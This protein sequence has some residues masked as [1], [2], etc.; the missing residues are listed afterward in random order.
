VS[1]E[2]FDPSQYVVEPVTFQEAKAVVVAG[3][4]THSLTKGRLCFGMKRNGVIIGVAVY[5]QPSGRKVASSIW[6]GGDERNTI[7]LLRLFLWD[8]TGKNAESW[9]IAKTLRLLPDEVRAVVAYAAP[10]A[11]HYGAVYQASNWLYV[12]RSKSGQNYYYTDADG[13]YVNKRIPWQYGPRS[14]RPE[15]KEAEAA[16]I[17]GL[18]R[19]NEGR[20]YV[21]VYPIDKRI[22][23]KLKR[24]IE[25]YPKP[26][27]QKAVGAPDFVQ[28]DEEATA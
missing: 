12:G 28:Q 24:Q 22:K 16:K 10:G 19:V 7:E 5:G 17:L 6:D 14:G 1:A 21:Y 20:K 27:P 25:D 23:K 26:E 11:G 3:H 15:I 2:R 18:E 13:M 4:Y 8:S 9:F